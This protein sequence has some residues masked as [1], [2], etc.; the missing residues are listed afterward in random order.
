[1]PRV[2]RAQGEVENGVVGRKSRR[3][4][5]YRHCAKL[6]RAG[7]EPPHGLGLSNAPAASTNY[8]RNPHTH[9]SAQIRRGVVDGAH[10][11]FA[12]PRF[13]PYRP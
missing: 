6:L 4:Q 10:V 2:L 3:A 5:V 11:V 9:Q 13:S 1:M 7:F 12:A 8:R